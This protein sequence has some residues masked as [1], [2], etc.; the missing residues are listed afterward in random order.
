MCNSLKNN[1]RKSTFSQIFQVEKRQVTVFLCGLDWTTQES[2]EPLLHFS[3]FEGQNF[4]SA[5]SLYIRE[6]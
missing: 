2:D 6:F 1:V 3:C 4:V 5:K